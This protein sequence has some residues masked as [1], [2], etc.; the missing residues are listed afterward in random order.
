MAEENKKPR[1]WLKSWFNNK[2]GAVIALLAVG[3]AP[4]ASA[5]NLWG[6]KT[7]NDNSSTT[8]ITNNIDNSDN[9]TTNNITNDNGELDNLGDNQ[10]SSL[11]Q[12]REGCVEEL[13]RQ[14]VADPEAVCS[15]MISKAQQQTQ[16]QGGNVQQY[17][18]NS[19]MWFM[20]NP[21]RPPAIYYGNPYMGSMGLWYAGYAW[22][23][24]ALGNYYARFGMMAMRD[25][26]FLPRITRNQ[27]FFLRQPL[28]R[29]PPFLG[30]RGPLGGL[31]GGRLPGGRLPGPGIPP[32][33]PVGPRL[34]FPHP[35]RTPV[36]PPL[37]GRPPVRPPRPIPRPMPRP[38]VQR[39]PMPRMPRPAPRAPMPRMPRGGGFGGGRWGRR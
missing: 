24:L 20:L 32:R 8:N 34:P 28:L 18:D 5:C 36:R 17:N 3:V 6:A 11:V 4:L 16:A 7:A 22:N 2:A 13:R 38:P 23:A 1:G 26:M 27:F 9:S 29:R 31:P 14:G 33:G 12:G 37:G 10:G 30:R 19:Q 35:P 21:N 25:F 39:N 15:D